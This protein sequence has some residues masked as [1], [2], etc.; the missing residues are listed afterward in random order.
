MSSNSWF[1]TG[2]DRRSAQL[3]FCIC[4][5]P[6]R[7]S[8]CIVFGINWLLT[9]LHVRFY[10]M[11]Q[12][13]SQEPKR[14]CPSISKHWTVFR[15]STA[16]LKSKVASFSLIPLLPL[17]ATMMATRSL[18]LRHLTPTPRPF[19]VERIDQGPSNFWQVVGFV[20]LWT[21]CCWVPL[22]ISHIIDRSQTNPF[23]LK[24]L[25]C[26]ASSSCPRRRAKY[27]LQSLGCFSRWITHTYIHRNLSLITW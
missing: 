18:L 23:I 8:F 17:Q 21:S 11:I 19:Q 10:C 14:S 22:L 3:I 6:F 26:F 25:D 27:C 15:I 2:S 9:D 4:F 12:R 20:S 16:C 24:L 1:V 13:S 5:H 7:L